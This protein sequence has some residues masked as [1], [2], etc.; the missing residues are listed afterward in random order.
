MT[1]QNDGT[2]KNSLPDA[3]ETVSNKMSTHMPTRVSE[4]FNIAQPL[5]N[6]LTAGGLFLAMIFDQQLRLLWYWQTEQA[7]PDLRPQDLVTLISSLSALT[8]DLSLTESLVSLAAGQR[9]VPSE[10]LLLNGRQLLRSVSRSPGTEAGTAG[11]FVTYLDVTPLR[12]REQEI[13]QGLERYQLAAEAGGIGTWLWDSQTN[14]SVW[15]DVE[16]RLLGVEPAEFDGTADLFWQ[17]LHPEDRSRVRAA[18]ERVVDAG[19]EFVDEFR[20]ILPDQ[21]TRWIAARGRRIFNGQNGQSYVIGINFD[22]TAQKNAQQDRDLRLA[23]IEAILQ[24][25]PVP[26]AVVNP[27][28][29]ITQTNRLM[30]DLLQDVRTGQSPDSF[31]ASTVPAALKQHVKQVFETGEPI[32]DIE[33]TG[34]SQSSS[35]SRR[36]WSLNIAPIRMPNG[37]VRRVCCTLQEVTRMK[38]AEKAGQIIT[39]YLGEQLEQR[40]LVAEERARALQ[41]MSQELFMT[42][43]NER[44]RLARDLHDGLGQLIVVAKMRLDLYRKKLGS[45][46]DPLLDQLGEIIDDAGRSVRTMTQQLAP[47][48]LHE[49]GMIA[50]LEWLAEEMWR[51]YQLRLVVKGECEFPS[52]ADK[53]QL[54]IFRALRELAVNVARHA[55]CNEALVCFRQD[56]DR[57]VVQMIDQGVGCEAEQRVGDNGGGFGLFSIRER[58]RYIGGE[59]KFVSAPSDGTV[60]SL[61]VPLETGPVDESGA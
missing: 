35:A 60:V 30:N 9:E 25:S 37:R 24:A 8:Q 15:D 11:Y 29:Q 56:A 19:E 6:G 53:T 20:I 46:P 21:Q 51:L 48:V 59:M 17:R 42:E 33:L 26:M 61:Y 43:E 44:K 14:Q 12:E 41:R 36:T 45:T 16:L 32:S 54:V 23:K 28:M 31:E 38:R 18:L 3:A 49:L 7:W 34:L 2:S 39:E 10:L 4:T 50:A 57:L 55:G 52:L 40:T 58:M 27:A 13:V 47:Q 22:I 1:E 5:I